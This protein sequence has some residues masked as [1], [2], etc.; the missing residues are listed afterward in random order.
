MARRIRFAVES[1]TSGGEWYQQQT[2]SGDW[3]FATRAEAE[4]FATR[5][6]AID[7]LDDIRNAV[8]VARVSS[9]LRAG[10]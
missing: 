3:D 9:D 10:G 7:L 5:L 1:C 8:R 6:R 2:N 4:T